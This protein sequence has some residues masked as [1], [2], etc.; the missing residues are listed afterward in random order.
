MKDKK[1]VV[2]CS[3]KEVDRV[4]NICN[5]IFYSDYLNT[6]ILK[7]NHEI[8]ARIKS[9]VC[10]SLIDFYG[11]AYKKKI[12]KIID[13][14]HIAS[15]ANTLTLSN[16]INFKDDSS[17]FDVK[18]FTDILLNRLVEYSKNSSDSRYSSAYYLTSELKKKLHVKSLDY[19]ALFEGYLIHLRSIMRGETT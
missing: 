5:N 11:E 9:E 8:E 19:K 14:I 12:I 16:K 2:A 6:G 10:E 15:I 17:K 7:S 4:V 18:L 13:K 1:S 3:Q